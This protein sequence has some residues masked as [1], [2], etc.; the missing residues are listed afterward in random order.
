[1]VFPLNI[2]VIDAWGKIPSGILYGNAY[3]LGQF[4][5]CLT[6]EK[7]ADDQDPNILKGQYCLTQ[8]NIGS[9]IGTSRVFDEINGNRQLNKENR[10]KGAG[11]ARMMPTQGIGLEFS[12]VFR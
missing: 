6:I 1:M 12:L 7:P 9:D 11:A 2:T 5:E 8:L 4:D 3:E 10:L